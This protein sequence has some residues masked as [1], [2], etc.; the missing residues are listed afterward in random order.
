MCLRT[1]KQHT[2]KRDSY[3]IRNKRNFFRPSVG[4]F[5]L[6]IEPCS[7]HRFT[8]RSQEAGGSPSRRRKESWVVQ[9]SFCN[10]LDH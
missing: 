2:I 8:Q 6:V 5:C 4:R 1:L 10:F 3:P 7:R 9:H